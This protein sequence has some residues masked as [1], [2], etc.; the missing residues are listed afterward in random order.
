MLDVYIIEIDD[1]VTHSRQISTYSRA[2]KDEL[3]HR[4]IARGLPIR[5]AY[6]AYDRAAFPVRCLPDIRTDHFFGRE[7]NIQR[8]HKFLGN[9]EEEKLRTYLIYGRRGVGKTQIALEYAQRFQ[10]KFDAVFWVL[11][12]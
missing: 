3:A 7:E 6:S 9:Q 10:S 8:I 4:Y 11:S 2:K 1:V 5:N 12:P